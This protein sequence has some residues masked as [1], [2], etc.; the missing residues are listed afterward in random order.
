M[1][2]KFL[3]VLFFSSAILCAR[4]PFTIMIDPAGDAQNP[5]REIGESFER[6]LT[7]QCANKLKQELIQ[8][9]PHVQV[10]ITRTPG[11]TVQSLHYAIFANR[12]RPNLYLRIGFYQEQCMPTN[13]ALFY[14]CQNPTDFWHKPN[15][16]QFYTIDQAHLLYLNLTKQFA[17]SFLKTLQNNQ[18]NSVFMS[19]GLFAVPIK[20]LVGI[21]AP[22]LYLEAGLYHAD[23]WHYLIKPIVACMQ[24]IA[25]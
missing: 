24:E 16:L 3:F 4:E 12:V 15:P 23:D 7:L 17:Q 19:Q 2:L 5:G 10:I 8:Q 18:I 9:I 22:A 20:P 1:S 25:R 14:Y 11:E 21:Q 13:F 6:G